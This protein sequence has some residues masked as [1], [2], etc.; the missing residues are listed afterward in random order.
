MTDE[1]KVFPAHELTEEELNLIDDEINRA[2]TV[3][4]NLVIHR[5]GSLNSFS[6]LLGYNKTKT[7][8]SLADNKFITEAEF[9]CRMLDILDVNID[10]V[11]P[12]STYTPDSAAER[13]I[14]DLT[15]VLQEPSRIQAAG[16]ALKDM[17]SY[18]KKVDMD[19]CDEVFKKLLL[20]MDDRRKKEAESLIRFFLS[21]T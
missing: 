20:F 11:F 5:Y 10:E 17:D 21:T 19:D 12:V 15:A 18:I 14:D 13:G 4:K 1:M 16:K 2:N 9:Y 8:R 7:S 3:I 6:Q